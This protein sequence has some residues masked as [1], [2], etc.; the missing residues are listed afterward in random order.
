[1]Q[2]DAKKL[3]QLCF[4]D[5]QSSPP[6]FVESVELIRRSC[7]QWLAEH[8]LDSYD[9]V[10]FSLCFNQLLPSL[11][12]VKRLKECYPDTLI[13]F[14]GSSCCG[15]IGASLF[16]HFAEID[17]LVDGEGENALR[18]L[19]LFLMG[20][21]KT[22][23]HSIRSRQQLPPADPP[24]APLNLDDF[25][26]PDYG[27][28]FEER[29]QLFPANPFNPVLPL[30]FS[31]GCWWNK[32][33][34]CN[35]NIQWHDYR[36]KS[37][38]RMIQETFYLAKRHASLHFTFTDN[39]LPLKR[40]DYFFRTLEGKQMDFDFFAEIRNV[41]D[42]ERLALYKRGGL[43]TVQVGIEALSSSLLAK[44]SKGAE[45]IDNIAVM[46]LCCRY[47]IHLE[48]NLITDFPTTTEAEIAETL[49][50]LEYLLPFSPLQPAT[51]FLGHG[52]PIHRRKE[53]FSILAVL[54]HPKN[55]QLFP[56]T[57]LSSMQMLVNGYRGDRTHQRKMWQPVREKLK[58]WQDFHHQR[59]SDRQLPLHYRDGQD[60]II[61]RQERLAGP[62]LIH[63]M[64]GLSRKIYLACETPVKK[65]WLRQ[66]FPSLSEQKLQ[67]FIDDLCDKR[68]MFQ[69]KER[70]LSLAVRHQ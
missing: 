33:T 47:G 14:G 16:H 64:R 66:S 49:T 50:N 21:K 4:K 32:C 12:M 70:V 23:P 40:A 29:N 56:D 48:G 38:D 24:A 19:S 55:R 30:E 20:K 3:Y 22:L 59:L 7:E 36:S 1:K 46:K 31:R 42:P 5:R 39:A 63:R 15:E 25:P 57:Y 8:P 6:P 18:S 69:D 67:N 53:E 58:Q 52:S 41:T 45:V 27:S 17:Y 44:M 9:L 51:F 68:I 11:Y 35:L 62:P 60:F 54:P 37:A 13:V 26:F 61:V 2:E 65:L 28:Y 10:G 43:N 34:F